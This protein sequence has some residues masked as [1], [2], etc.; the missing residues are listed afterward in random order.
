MIKSQDYTVALARDYININPKSSKK[1]TKANVE[2][3][4][5]DFTANNESLKA[6]KKRV[7]EQ[8]QELFAIM[9]KQG[10]D[11]LQ[12]TTMQGVRSFSERD[13]FD[14]V[15]LKKED[16]TTYNKY[17]VKSLVTSFKVI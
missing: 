9:D 1:M 11:V 13:R 12:G 5:A 14:S 3:L 6:L 4:L 10:M 17:V 16:F 7:E 2:K 8:K 15:T